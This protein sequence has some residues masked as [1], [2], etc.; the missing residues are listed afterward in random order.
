MIRRPPR[1][2]LFPY[3]TLFRSDLVLKSNVVMPTGPSG[4]T[5]RFLVLTQSGSNDAVIG[6]AAI[7]IGSRGK[8]T[9][10]HPNGKAQ[11]LN[12]ITPKIRIPSSSLKKKTIHNHL[13]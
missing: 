7:G 10:P 13:H 12:P 8:D 3:T 2:T 1:S 4:K 5:W 11:R 6:N 9:P